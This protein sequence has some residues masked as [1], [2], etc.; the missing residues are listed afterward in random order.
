MFNTIRGGMHLS[1]EQLK[2]MVVFSQVVKYGSLIGASRHLGI[3]RAVVSYHIKQLEKSLDVKLL[4][5]STRSMSLT[6]EGKIY[7][8]SCKTI[9]D[10][11]EVASRKIENMKN[12]PEGKLTITA[13]VNLGTRVIAP[14]LA[15][16]LLI[17]PRI[18]VNL[19]LTD[20]V[21]NIVHEGIDIAVRGA[22]LEDSELKST[23]LSEVKTY[24]C[25]SPDYLRKHGVPETPKDLSGHNWV[26]YNQ[27]PQVIS[28]SKNHR[29]HEVQMKGS[30]ITNNGSARTTLVEAGVGLGRI[31]EYDA[32]PG[33]E[34]GKLILLLSNY[35]LPSI[36]FYAV[37]SNGATS[38]KKIKIFIEFLR[39]HFS[40][41][42][43]G[44]SLL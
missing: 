21:V 13:A 43:R 5:R 12:E 22:P 24:I 38:S 27:L 39:N 9:A 7:Y 36:K 41:E 28:L 35:Q 14:L 1:F 10:E 11:A 26:C 6:E 31:P 4:N 29:H 44:F 15:K 37:F 25:A 33:I 42:D 19:T 16:F 32:M 3:S 17:Y 30:I 34:Q 18:E 40:A 23:L 20:E 8:E 2:S